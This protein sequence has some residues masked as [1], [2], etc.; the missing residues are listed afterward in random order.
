MENENVVWFQKSMGMDRK[1]NWADRCH[2]K[3]LANVGERTSKG[4]P[5][6]VKKISCLVFNAKAYAITEKTETS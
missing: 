5:L 3:L 2:S 4:R 1:R 6:P